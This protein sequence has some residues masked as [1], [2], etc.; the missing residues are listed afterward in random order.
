MLFRFA[1]VENGWN[2]NAS[3]RRIVNSHRRR[4]SRT[5]TN[6]KCQK[7]FERFF[8][9]LI[10]FFVA[11]RLFLR[12]FSCRRKI[13]DCVGLSNSVLCE[14]FC[15]T[16]QQLKRNDFHFSFTI[17][18]QSIDQIELFF[19]HFYRSTFFLT[20]RRM[21]HARTE[22]LFRIERKNLIGTRETYL[23]LLSQI[24][25]E[26]AWYLF[27]CTLHCGHAFQNAVPIDSLELD[28]SYISRIKVTTADK[29]AKKNSKL[30]FIFMPHEMDRQKPVL[31]LQHQD[32]VAER[33]H[34]EEQRTTLLP[35]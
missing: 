13:S 21:S 15:F 26:F 27:C 4:H 17:A 32:K 18:A 11:S 25:N 20:P 30:D 33:D 2:E 35:A 19:V 16:R 28:R 24:A 5:H 10:S 12:S 23:F 9:I 7:Q 29:N 34:L 3:Q 6:A 8:T 1:S 14:S 31:L 22:I